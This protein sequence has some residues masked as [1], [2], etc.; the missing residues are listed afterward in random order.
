M[1][2]I[3]SFVLSFACI[4]TVSTVSICAKNN[5]DT[6]E[7]I[8]DISISEPMTFSEMVSVYADNNDISFVEAYKELNKG[9]SIIT[10]SSLSSS[11]YRVLSIGLYVNSGY[12]PSIDYY[13]TT[14]ESGSYWGITSIYSVQLKRIYNGVSKVFQGNL[15]SWLRSPYQI[16]YIINGDFYNQATS[17]SSYTINGSWG[18]NVKISLSI[19]STNSSSYYASIYQGRTVSFQS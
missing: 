11:S 5:N 7:E 18:E 4:L 16:E 8:T 17:T 14:S 3:L 12:K 13:V 9:R 15:E 10:T 2:K 6:Q 1:K 19:N